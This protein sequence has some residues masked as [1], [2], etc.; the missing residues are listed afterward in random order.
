MKCSDILLQAQGVCKSFGVTKALSNLDFTLRYGQ[1]H[2]LIGE[3]GSGKSTFSSIIAGAQAADEGAFTLK[4]V[5]YHP[6]SMPEAVR[7]GVALIIQEQGTF[8][9]A[10][11]AENIF[12]GR[13]DMF[14]HKG[15]LNV[16]K[17]NVEARA[18]LDMIGA[19]AIREK[20]P[21]KELS[22]EQRKILEIAR[23]AYSD[24]CVLIVDETS[25]VLS[26]EGRDVLYT[27]MHKMRDEGKAVLF[28]THDVAEMIEHSDEI[29]VLRDGKLVKTLKK[30]EFSENL[31]KELMIGRKVEG[32]YYRSDTHPTQG[33]KVRLYAKD[34]CYK[35]LKHISFD[36]HE[37]EIFGVGGLSDCG[38]HELGK[39]LYGVIPPDVG[40][41]EIGEGAHKVNH[42]PQAD[43]RNKCAY[44]SKDRDTE[45]LMKTMTI[46]ENISLLSLDHL[47]KLCFVT[48]KQERDFCAGW[49]ETL[50][51]RMRDMEQ[52]VMYLSGGNKQKVALAKWM[53]FDPEVYI[54]D[55][56]TRGIDVGA[57]AAIVKL[58]RK[59]KAEGRAVVLISEE[60]PELIGLSDRILII[61]NGESQGIFE[62]GPEMTEASLINYMI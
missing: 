35:K 27:L 31:I 14:V 56:P 10:S 58:I 41:V 33:K 12:A 50:D 21:V 22:F 44:I 34:L 7:S 39:I 37:G 29:T 15:L 53:A 55:C 19:T 49:K 3:N 6:A 8:P 11:V 51:I 36:V 61:K 18:A 4:G 16:Q 2:G 38:M 60:L 46:R 20:M 54:M 9:A 17:M 62:R 28:I 25:A 23:A 42:S 57:K 5:A 1:I 40:S 48:K 59:F 45:S 52:F 13:E 32:D 43:I 24:P 30:E 26:K 47:K